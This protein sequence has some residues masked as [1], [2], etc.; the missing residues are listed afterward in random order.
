ME[1]ENKSIDECIT[2]YKPAIFWKDKEIVRQ[3]INYWTLKDIQKLI[4]QVIKKWLSNNSQ[5]LEN[6]DYFLN[7]KPSKDKKYLESE[8]QYTD[9]IIASIHRKDNLP[10]IKIQSMNRIIQLLEFQEY[11][12]Q[13][14][15]IIEIRRLLE[16]YISLNK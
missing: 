11:T 6:K 8:F 13:A 14:K 7:L 4:F 9:E 2:I 5:C 12:L 16:Y 1:K 3:Q 15:E 10:H